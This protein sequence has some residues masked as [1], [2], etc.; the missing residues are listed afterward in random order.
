MLKVDIEATRA[1]YTSLPLVGSDAS[2]TCAYCRN[3][4]E[5]HQFL[6]ASFLKICDDLGIDPR[7][8]SEV[9]EIIENEDGTRFY[10]GW[11][12]L[13]GKLVRSDDTLLQI[14][15]ETKHVGVDEPNKGFS[16]KFHTNVALVPDDFPK[17]VLQME[18]FCNIP[19]MLSEQP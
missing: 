12:H 16:I 6:P 10:G 17:P 2:C 7:R 14:E 9:Y 1:A 11:Y 4:R 8:P 15:P 3:F 19:W 18:I 5:A 13:V